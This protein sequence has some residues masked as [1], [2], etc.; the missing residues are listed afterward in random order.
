MHIVMWGLRRPLTGGPGVIHFIG[1][2]LLSKVPK[3]KKKAPRPRYVAPTPCSEDGRV[4]SDHRYALS[5]DSNAFEAIQTRVQRRGEQQ[6]W[7]S[8]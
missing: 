3:H 1:T 6:S 7:D 4:A 2:L 5:P 8:T